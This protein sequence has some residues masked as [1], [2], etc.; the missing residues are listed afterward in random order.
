MRLPGVLGPYGDR[1]HQLLSSGRVEEVEFSGSTYQVL[2]AP[3]SGDTEGHWAFLQLGAGGELKDSFCGCEQADDQGGC[4]HLATAYLRIFGDNAIPLHQLFEDSVWNLLCRHYAEKLGYDADVL[5]KES[6][7]CYSSF[8]P[9]GK[10]L[11][12]VSSGTKGNSQH[13]ENLIEHRSEE[14]EETSLKFS[15]LSQDEIQL[16]REGRPSL[17]LLYHLSF[18]NDL[19]RWL[20]LLQESGAPYEIKFGMSPKGIPNRLKAT[21][22]AGSVEFYLPEVLLEHIIPSLS[23]INSPIPVRHHSEDTITAIYYD[24]ELGG[25]RVE[26]EGIGEDSQREVCSEQ[27]TWQSGEWSYCPSLGF[28]HQDQGGLLGRAEITGDSVSQFLTRYYPLLKNR[29][30]DAK[31]YDERVEVSHHLLFDSEWNLHI[32]YYVKEVGD[33]LRP[34]SRKFGNWVYVQADGL[35]QVKGMR[36]SGLETVIPASEVGDFVTQ[37][38]VWL[39]SQEGFSPHLANVEADISY[40]VDHE[41]NLTF[42]SFTAVD[43]EAGK[44]RDFG[45][46]VYIAE[47]GFFSKRGS[48][49]GMSVYAGVAIPEEAVAPF[50]RSHRDELQLVSGFVNDRCPVISSE[51]RVELSESDEILVTPTYELLPE[52]DQEKLSFFGEYVYSPGEGFTELPADRRLPENYRQPVVVEPENESLFLG[53]ELEKLKPFIAHLDSRLRRPTHMRLIA[54]GITESSLGRGW[55][56]LRLKYGTDRGSISAA[57]LWKS[58]VSGERFV[59]SDAGLFDL[60]ETRYGWFQGLAKK[61]VDLRK[62]VVTLSTLELVRLHVLEQIHP[63]TGKGVEA[64]NTRTLLKELTS[65]QHPSVPHLD[66]LNSTLRPYQESGV[67]WLWF[68]YQHGLSGLLCDDMGLGKT[69]QSMALMAAIRSEFV[70]KKKTKKPKFLVVCP[71]SVIYH[72]EE[73]LLEFLPNLRVHIFYGLDRTLEPFDED[74]DVLLTSYGIWRREQENLKKY[75]FELAIFDEIQAAKNTS[76]RLH[77]A[78]KKVNASMRLGLTGTPIENHLLELKALFDVV[79]PSYM[80][81]EREYRDFFLKPIEKEYNR[82]RKQLLI[83]LVDPFLLRRKKEDVLKDLPEKTE[84]IFHCHLSEEQRILYQE[85]LSKTRKQVMDDLHEGGRSVPYI[86][87][88]AILSQLKRICNHPAAFLKEPSAYRSHSSGKWDLFVE[89]LSEAR[90]SGQKVVIFSQYLTML[91]IFEQYLSEQGIQYASIRGSTQKRGE[92]LRK[93]N[94]DPE[95]EVFL[96]SLQ[97]VGLGVDLTAASVVIHYDRWWNA[98]RENQATDRVHRMGQTRGVQVFKLVTKG[99]FE[100]RIDALISAKGALMEDVIGTDDQD[101][102]KCLDR[103]QLVELLQ[104]VEDIL[105]SDDPIADSEF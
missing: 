34:R 37:Q 65:F 14:T 4:V 71:T 47:Q 78:L 91:D 21:F 56:A 102:I 101:V 41:D 60:Q 64:Q 89:L 80:P 61:R 105:Q 88:F 82:Q 53:Y 42:H 28:V 97:A 1:A 95:C 3:D 48:Q 12:K 33:L 9:T 98:A 90:D 6:D 74:C 85:V 44:H 72:W 18:W 51:L 26:H 69:H 58:S 92:Q 24:E 79:L 10:C 68:L 46:W 15:D 45:P 16:W 11:F 49:T 83:R 50:I 36:F 7:G 52:Y 57:R 87:I 25:F 20:M 93:F 35:Y 31:L 103:D 63:P 5:Q 8:S 73:K 23:S 70:A 39:S 81:G 75:P 13:L 43:E 30:K 19:A 100:E 29:L 96:G 67:Q 54:D 32:Q 59:F 76:S 38:R 77:G 55:Y 62:G 27:C 86:H 104:D 17:R 66:E 40:E 22:A 94:Q 84:E 2:V 99:T